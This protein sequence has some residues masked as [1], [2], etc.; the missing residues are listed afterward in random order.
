M[1]IPC[2]EEAEITATKSVRAKPSPLWGRGLGEG[3]NLRSSVRSTLTP[4][5]S[6][7]GRGSS[8]TRS[9]RS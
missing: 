6:L 3:E 4:T 5:L 7:P 8:H 2:C 9:K 1:A